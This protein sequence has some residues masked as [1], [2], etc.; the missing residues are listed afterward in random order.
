MANKT[1]SRVRVTKAIFRTLLDTAK[2]KFEAEAIQKSVLIP[3]SKEDYFGFGKKDT[4]DSVSLF[5]FLT[6]N[7]AV[8]HY[9]RKKEIKRNK[10][11]PKYFYNISLEASKLED[12]EDVISADV[13]YLDILAVYLSED[14]EQYKLAVAGDKEARLSF[15]N[16]EDY[17]DK[18]PAISSEEREVQLTLLRSDPGKVSNNATSYK[19]YYYSYREFSI[20]EFDIS[21]DYV[22]QDGGKFPVRAIGIHSQGDS[23]TDKRVYE[24]EA[25]QTTTCLSMNLF[26]TDHNHPLTIIGYTSHQRAKNMRIIISTYQ[27]ISL[28]GYPISAET[29]LVK[30]GANMQEL[31]HIQAYLRIQRRNFYI[32]PR[33]HT[34]LKQ[35]KARNIRTE[36]LAR[37]VGR[38]CI[39][40]ISGKGQIVQSVFTI[41]E[42]YGAYLHT[43]P[44]EGVRSRHVCVMSVSTTAGKKLCVSSH[45][46][47]GISVINYAIINCFAERDGLSNGVYCSIGPHE[48]ANSISGCLVAMKTTEDIEAKILTNEDLRQLLQKGTYERM[49]H[50][51]LELSDKQKRQFQI[52]GDRINPLLEEL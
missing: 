50:R 30:N 38:Y 12:T 32:P 27:G 8:Q 15:K 51:L 37:L 45:P 49:F 46:S 41:D 25:F 33:I 28:W 17:V 20:K 48:Q 34:D 36:E 47:I 3:S 11:N 18:N 26:N 24:G 29:I 1:S 6:G 35:L 7:K 14:I 2:R 10:L 22:N 16:F 21:I 19:A 23:Q 39:W 44:A 52:L 4:K 42:D 40:N 43:L 9:F 31:S 13:K 5:T